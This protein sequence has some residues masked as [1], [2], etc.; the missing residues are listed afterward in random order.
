MATGCAGGCNGHGFCQDVEGTDPCV[1]EY[2]WSGYD[3]QVGTCPQ[4]RAWFDEAISTT[5][6]HQLATCSNMGTCDKSTGKCSCAHGYSGDACQ[7]MDCPFSTDGTVQ[8]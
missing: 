1:C 7:R 3:C 2:G 4:G 8:I 6:A 5:E